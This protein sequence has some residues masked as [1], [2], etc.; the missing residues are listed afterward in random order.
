MDGPLK[1]PPVD[2]KSDCYER[3]L[4]LLAVLTQV[5]LAL[6]YP[7]ADIIDVLHTGQ[8]SMDYGDR[9]AAS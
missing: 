8:I 5:L 9:L 1:Q 4:V 6:T 3:A 7:L 2:Q